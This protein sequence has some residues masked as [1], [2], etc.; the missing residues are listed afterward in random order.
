MVVAVVITP[1]RYV[2]GLEIAVI[3]MCVS[4]VLRYQYRSIPIVVRVPCANAVSVRFRCIKGKSQ[5]C[6]NIILCLR[7]KGVCHL[8][9]KYYTLYQ[10][11]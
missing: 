6:N 11:D 2:G 9:S 1:D 4:C 5:K 3:S 7:G 8:L 10:K